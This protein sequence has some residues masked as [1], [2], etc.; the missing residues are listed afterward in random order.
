MLAQFSADL[1]AVMRHSPGNMQYLCKLCL[2]ETFSVILVLSAGVHAPLCG[3][4]HIPG[5]ERRRDAR[6]PATSAGKP[7]FMH[8][9]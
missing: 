8:P 2:C 1:A 3:R 5:G 9:H 7:T 4:N 6:P